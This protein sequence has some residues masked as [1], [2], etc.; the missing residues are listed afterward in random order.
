MTYRLSHLD[1]LASEAIHIIREVVAEFERPALLFSGGKDSAVLLHLAAKACWPQRV[2]FPVVH[3][4]TGH[5]FPEVIDYRDHQVARARRSPRRRLGAGGHRPGLDRRAAGAGRD[6]QPAA[7]LHPAEGAR[8]EPLRRRLRRGP[9]RRGEGEG[10]GADLLAAR[11]VRPVGP[12]RA[13]APSC[14]TSTTPATAPASTSGSSRSRTGPSST[15]G[16]TSRSSSSS[17]R[18]STSPTAGGLPAR[19]ACCS[20]SGPGHRPADGVAE[21]QP[22]EATVRYRTVGDMTCTAAVE[23]TAATPAEVIAE[24]A[25]RR[26]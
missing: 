14:G 4:D 25:R 12:P 23:S 16:S 19:R 22:F 18:R 3:V 13:S 11:R 24:T 6:A 2:P 8:G 7:D 9:A 26:E 1:A 20:R 21:E 15:S 17:C 5:N 10:Q